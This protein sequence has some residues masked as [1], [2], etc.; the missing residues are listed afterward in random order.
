MTWVVEVESAA[1]LLRLAQQDQLQSHNGGRRLLGV[2]QV[3]G[4]QD[5]F[6]QYSAHRS[7]YL[8]RFPDRS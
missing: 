4:N 5:I 8:S 3:R 2:V 6:W 1:V 7:G